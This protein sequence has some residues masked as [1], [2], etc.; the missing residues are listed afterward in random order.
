M[1][2][3]QDHERIDELLAG[4]A[5]RSL[6]GEDAREADRLL[7]DHVP[8]CT[9]C[10][11][12]LEAFSHVVGDLALTTEPM[13]P[14]DMLLPRLHR[15]LEPRARRAG[16]RWTGVA[17]GLA[18]IV[19]SGGLAISQGLRAGALA[20]QQSKLFRA[21]Q[22]AAQPGANSLSIPPADPG[23]PDPVA[24]ITAP[25]EQELYLIGRNVPPPPAGYV[26]RVWLVE[27]GVPVYAGEFLPGP[28]GI[29]EV[30][31]VDPTSLDSVRITVEPA[32]STPTTP[33]HAVW[34]AAA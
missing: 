30:F 23:G 1:V 11:E 6:T 12:T 28:M 19:I 25:Q 27:T 22:A 4:Y 2:D 14:P 18:V 5:L 24:G 13:E 9:R 26:Y 10:R 15:E 16:A 29:V 7:S 20:D 32:G 17:A 21:A 8:S 31:D 33:G 3:P 34:E